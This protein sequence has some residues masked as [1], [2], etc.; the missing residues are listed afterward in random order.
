[1]PPLTRLNAVKDEARRPVCTGEVFPV[2]RAYKEAI[3]S[4]A[5]E[6][7]FVIANSDPSA[8]ALTAE[9]VD[10]RIAERVQGSLQFLDGESYTGIYCLSKRMRKDL[11]EETRVLSRDNPAVFL[12]HME[13]VS[14]YT[15]DSDA[16]QSKGY[17]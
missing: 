8:K 15:K 16:S 9:E 5:D 10:R 1:M 7:G 14:Q 13:G 2:A 4:F 17:A 12:K 6:W 11:S 3:Y